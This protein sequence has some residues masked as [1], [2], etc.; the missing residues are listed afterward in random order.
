MGWRANE[1]TSRWL[2]CL[3]VDEQL[4]LG[5]STP[6]FGYAKEC[7]KPTASLTEE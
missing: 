7:P 5:H 2:F 4:N 1:S 6:R 3:E